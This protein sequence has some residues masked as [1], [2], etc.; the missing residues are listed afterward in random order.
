[1]V[2]T[3][4]GHIWWPY[5]VTISCDHIWWPYLVTNIL[6]LPN[7]GT[8]WPTDC[9]WT[10]YWPK[11]SHWNTNWPRNC[12]L[13]AYWPTDWWP[14]MVALSGDHIWS[15]QIWSL[16]SVGQYVVQWQ[17][18]GQLPNMVTTVCRSA[19]SSVT[20]C[21]SVSSSVTVR[22]WPYV[23]T[24]SNV[25]YLSLNYLLTYRLSLNYLLTY[26][27]VTIYGSLVRWPYLELPNMVTTVCRSACSSVTV[28]RSVSSSVTVRLTTKV[29]H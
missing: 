12:H 16:Q 27:L 24:I 14:Y 21:R 26:R 4:G 5:L 11:V 18:V 2:T 6:R 9:H 10:T 17:S 7:M 15:Y 3:S 1:M 20:V 25:Q 8:Y 23:M 28:C 13:T 29:D 19:C 22:L